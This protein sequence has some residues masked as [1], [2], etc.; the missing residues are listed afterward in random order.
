[1]RLM[2]VALAAAALSGCVKKQPTEVDPDY[3][4]EGTFSPEARL[5]V[6][7]DLPTT[8]LTFFDK[9][10]DPLTPNPIGDSLIGTSQVRRG[11]AGTFHLQLF[12]GTQAGAFELLRREPGGGYFSV[13]DYLLPP[14]RKWID[15]QRELYVTTDPSPS[16]YTPATYLMRG[17]VGGEITS[18]SPLTNAAI[19]S[20]GIL[21]GITYTG[22]TS[23]S[24][25]LFNIAWAP[26]TGAAGYWVHVY[27]F[28]EAN[29]DQQVLSGV[30]APAYV[31]KER[32]FF[33]GYVPAPNTS[34]KLGTTPADV[35]IYTRRLTLRGQVYFVRI[36]AVDATG[37]LIAMTPGDFG[38]IPGE[39]LE[40]TLFPLGAK[41][42]NVR[43]A[44]APQAALRPAA[45]RDVPG[46]DLWM[47]DLAIVR[48]P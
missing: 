38:M 18:E 1:V 32:N 22:V 28:L 21:E 24:D 35:D 12:D 20:G 9:N 6:Y 47:G 25:S 5:I 19:A 42:I 31:E 13:N 15:G 44:S 26:V 11:S 27:Q 43:A 39:N 7:P 45:L 34:Y 36:A 29:R 23:P 10:L 17:L 30:P 4:P 3:V 48:R 16:A 33:L 46:V 41:A 8:L 14:A 2:A 37:A 40:Y